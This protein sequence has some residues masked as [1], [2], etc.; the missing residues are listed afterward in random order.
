MGT[1]TQPML[2]VANARPE[3]KR[4]FELT[5]V[6]PVYNEGPVVREFLEMLHRHARGFTPDVE[7]IVVNDGSTDESCSEILRCADHLPMRYLE[8]SRNFGKEH[9][10]QAGIDAASGDCVVIIDAD[11]QH[12]IELIGPMIERWQ[13]GV[14]MVYAVKAHRRGEPLWR[15]ALGALF[16]RMLSVETGAKIPPDAGD[17]R[18]LDRKIADVLRALPERTRFMKGLYAWVGFKSEA[19]PFHPAPRRGGVTKYSG[20]RLTRLAL[21]GITAFSSLP[22]RLVSVAGLAIS[23][24][25]FGM[26]CWIVLEKMLLHQSIPGF[27]TVAASVSFLSGIQLLALGIVGEYVGRVF[28]EVKHR[29]PYVVARTLDT[30]PLARPAARAAMASEERNRA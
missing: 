22:L 10:I 14:D 1:L 15:R 26:G 29:P 12:P 16:Y 28:D 17:F 27:A 18:L 25:A 9:A 20:P 19:I 30:T 4:R 7:L 6:V 24:C 21:S 2:Y 13:R 11:F 23:V 8:L 5:C 3:S